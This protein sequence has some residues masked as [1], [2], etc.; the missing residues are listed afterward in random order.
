MRALVGLRAREA[1]WGAGWGRKPE[2][3]QAQRP[4]PRRFCDHPSTSLGN[5]PATPSWVPSPGL[6]PLSLLSP[7]SHDSFQASASSVQT[8]LAQHLLCSLCP[9]RSTGISVTGISS[10]WGGWLGWKARG[11][12]H[13][14]TK[15]PGDRAGLN[16]GHQEQGQEQGYRSRV[17]RTNVRWDEQG[18]ARALQGPLALSP[19][20]TGG[21][22]VRLRLRTR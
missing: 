7:P 14:L 16:W 15:V 19:P 5:L 12:G 4:L 9:V 6:S 8:H 18:C 2:A 3:G 20:S 21:G 1:L 10:A 17:L 22:A 11:W 13:L